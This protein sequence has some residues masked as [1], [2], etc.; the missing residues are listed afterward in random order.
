MSATAGEGLLSIWIARLCEAWL[1]TLDDGLG[2]LLQYLSPLK[3]E[4]D[5]DLTQIE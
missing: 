5:S 4:F 1:L 2:E 3:D